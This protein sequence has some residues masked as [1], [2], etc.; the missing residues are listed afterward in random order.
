MNTTIVAFANHKGGVGKTASV[1]NVSSILASCGKKVLMIDLDAQANLTLSFLSEI[2]GRTI[3]NAMIDRKDMPVYSIKEN[4]DI[5]PSSLEMIDIDHKIMPRRIENILSDLVKKYKNRY[6]YII[7]DCPP[8]LGLLTINALTIADKLCVPMLADKMS[9]IGVDM[10]KDFCANEMQE[11]NPGIHI[12]HIF[13]TQYLKSNL[14][15]S[16]EE[17]MR[18]DYGKAVA[19]TIIRQNTAIKEAGVE[20]KD[21]VTY[22][23]DS[24]GAQDYMALVCELFNVKM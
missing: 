16:V 15:K 22:S 6:D 7:L 5:T 24:N 2:P 9:M 4:L 13:I 19:Q 23:P 3:Y 12:D 17:Q 20:L 11:L 10:L 18:A 1:A 8:S 21:I 14:A